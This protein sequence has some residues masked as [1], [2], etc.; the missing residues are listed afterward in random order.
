MTKD[1]V[2]DV[3]ESATH[4]VE[5]GESEIIIDTAFLM[6]DGQLFTADDIVKGGA[7]KKPSPLEQRATAETTACPNGAMMSKAMPGSNQTEAKDRSQGI[8]LY[9]DM[10]EP[11]YNPTMLAKFLDA[12]ET[13][14][15]CVKVKVT[16]SVGRTW[17][18]VKAPRRTI[19]DSVFEAEQKTVLDFM[20]GANENNGIEGVL[21]KAAMD[22]EAVGWGCIEV[23]RSFDRRVK[24]LYHVPAARIRALKGGTGFVELKGNTPKDNRFYLPFGR[25]V[26]SSNRKRVDGEFETYDPL[27]DGPIEDSQWNLRNREDLN[28]SVGFRQIQKSAN[29]LLFI[30]KPHPKSI[31]YGIPDFIPAIGSIMGNIHIR[32]FLL[33]FFDH[34][35]V[36]QYAIIIKGAKLTNEV[37]DLIMAY[38][39]QEIKGNAHKTL[40]IPIPAAG[41]DVDVTFQPLQSGTL[42]GSF[43]ETRKNNQRSIIVA[44][45]LSPAV[46]GDVE[47]ASLGGGKGQAQQANYKNRVVDPLQKR[48]S[49]AMDRVFR[50]GLG[51]ANVSLE[52]DSLDAEDQTD[53][54]ENLTAFKDAG[55]LSLNDVRERAKMGGPIKGGDRPF[56]VVGDQIVFIEELQ[57]FAAAQKKVRDTPPQA[58]KAPLKIPAKVK[59]PE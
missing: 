20:D 49:R 2:L 30:S 51:A 7:V 4:V 31:Y 50:H 19:E 21:E 28:K 57:E 52:F 6:S 29:E 33:Q 8:N 22:Y 36:P 13:H 42:E 35:T 43:Q 1:P 34:N 45:G 23:I 41:G 32:D 47:T 11:P 17:T 38:F 25:K 14:F 48:W 9:Q 10:V 24:H 55:T 40:V 15:R 46:V 3:P 12:D 54:R 44:H 27:K 37:R 58:L 59:K 5:D 53:Q 26:L 39:S 18:L 56:I 16:D